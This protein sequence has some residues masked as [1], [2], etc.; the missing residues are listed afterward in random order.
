MDEPTAPSPAPGPEAPVKARPRLAGRRLAVALAAAAGGLYLLSAGLLGLVWYRCG[1]SGCPE[2]SR[3]RSYQ[4]GKASRLL[5]RQ[6]RAFG[7]LRPVDGAT[8][9]LRRIPAHV[10][11]AFLAVEDQRFYDHGA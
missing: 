7:E 5:D 3:L 4:P 8:V 10:R 2:V 11:D 6:G 1:L 9:P